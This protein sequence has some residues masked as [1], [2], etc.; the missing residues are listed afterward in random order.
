MFQYENKNREI[1]KE[2]TFNKG[3]VG[4][5]GWLFKNSNITPVE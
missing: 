5:Y 2:V 3:R 1:I 4:Q